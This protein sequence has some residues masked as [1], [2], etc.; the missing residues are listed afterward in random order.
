MQIV[1]AIP[2]KRAPTLELPDTQGVLR[3]ILARGELSV[4]IFAR[5]HWCF[6]CRRYLSKLQTRLED[7]IARSAHLAVITPEPPSTSRA[8]AVS[9]G[10]S[11]PI[12]A[13]S[14]GLAIDAFGVRNRFGSCS[15]LMPHASVFIVDADGVIRLRVV[16]RN[17]K[18]L[19]PIRSI[20]LA[21]DHIRFNPGRSAPALMLE[22]DSVSE[23]LQASHELRAR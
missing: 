17:Y 18:K 15:T 8:M 11:F 13:D 5:G 4:L 16:D 6:Y 2:G 21:V 9:L 1:Q 23:R 14:D 10:L 3:P 7:F 20:L 12:L 22:V 19:T